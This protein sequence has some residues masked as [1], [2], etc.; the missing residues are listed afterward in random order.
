ML[1]RLTCIGVVAALLLTSSTQFAAELKL[2]DV[3][4]AKGDGPDGKGNTADDTWQFWFE[5]AHKPGEFRRFTRHSSQIPAAGI[6]RKVTGP[7]A[8]LL[9]NPK[10]TTGWVLHTDWDARYEGIWSDKKTGELLAHPY[11]EKRAHMAVAITYLV[12]ADGVYTISGGVTDVQV[13]PEFAKHDGIIWKI[14]IAKEGA[15][16]K[17]LGQGKPVGDG[18]GR[19][20]SDKFNFPDVK[21]SKGQLVRLVIHPNKWWGQ[22]L[23][24][25][26]QFKIE[27]K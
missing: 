12:S 27:P 14:E 7:P 17:K 5:L 23:T 20:E 26:D 24:R 21:L 16:V 11:V 2:D 3:A 18:H 6:P 25:I 13:K 19:P 9:P 15:V 10:E 4:S 8:G 22:D 1:L